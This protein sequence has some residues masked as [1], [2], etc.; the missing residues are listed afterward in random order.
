M[1][2]N[3]P[4][5]PATPDV[6]LEV[7]APAPVFTLPDLSERAVSLGALCARGKPVALVFVDPGC[8]PCQALLPELGRWQSVLSDRLTIAG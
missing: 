8:G 2:R 1:A 6:E 4:H 5:A 3:Q 7:G